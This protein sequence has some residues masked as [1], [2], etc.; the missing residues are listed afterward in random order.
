M[1]WWERRKF[2][3]SHLAACT[4]A[5]LIVPFDSGPYR[6][7]L[8][9]RSKRRFRMFFR[10]DMSQSNKT[11]GV[12]SSMLPTP[13]PDKDIFITDTS[14][15]WADNSRQRLFGIAAAARQSVPEAVV[16][17]PRGHF[18]FRRADSAYA[19]GL[20]RAQGLRESLGKN[21]SQR[22]TATFIRD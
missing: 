21:E 18:N 12:A 16:R 1:P 9:A 7:G 17:R 4:L 3:L 20:A 19:A 22:E 14:A 15:P 10:Q 11:S 2:P 8:R 6:V 5:V 13:N